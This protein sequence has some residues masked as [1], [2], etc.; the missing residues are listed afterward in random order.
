MSLLQ[1]HCCHRLHSTR[2]P[3]ATIAAIP[4]PGK[5][6]DDPSSYRPISLLNTDTKLYAKLLA[7]RLTNIIPQLVHIVSGR[8]TSIGRYPQIYRSTTVGG[9][10]PNAFSAHLSQCREG[11][12]QGGLVL[13]D[14]G[15]TEIWLLWDHSA[16]NTIPL[17]LSQRWGNDFWTTLRPLLHL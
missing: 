13:F 8:Q 14:S 2:I 5:P 1:L 3:Q 10:P 11:I 12:C 15:L 16:S 6:I 17:L 9:T 4:K 7:T